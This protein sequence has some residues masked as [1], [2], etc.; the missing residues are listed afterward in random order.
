[1]RIEIFNNMFIKNSKVIFRKF[2]KQIWGD[3]LISIK[4]TTTS[5]S[6][7]YRPNDV[8]EPPED[9]ELRLMRHHNHCKEYHG[10]VGVLSE[11]IYKNLF[12]CVVPNERAVNG[13]QLVEMNTQ[14]RVQN[15]D[16]SHRFTKPQLDMLAYTFPYH[17][18]NT[19]SMNLYSYQKRLIK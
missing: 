10:K 14:A 9:Q 19:Y 15:D 8:V 3:L 16:N 5:E 18:Q 17:M 6:L 4:S 11:E 2:L 7:L 12:P 13:S 1:M